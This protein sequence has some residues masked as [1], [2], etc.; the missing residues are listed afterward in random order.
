MGVISV[1]ELVIRAQKAGVA[2][3]LGSLES[4]QKS[5]PA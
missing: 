4:R 3:A 5:Q 1:A 2:A